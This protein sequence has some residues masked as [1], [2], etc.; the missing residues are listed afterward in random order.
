MTNLILVEGLFIVLLVVASLSGIISLARTG[1]VLIGIGAINIALAF[2]SFFG[3]PV[4]RG[5]VSDMS[6]MSRQDSLEARAGRNVSKRNRPSR[7]FV[8]GLF[9]IGIIALGVG[10]LLVLLMP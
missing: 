9:V 6:P 2:L 8:F 7:G 10:T 1:R 5:D 4:L 3:W